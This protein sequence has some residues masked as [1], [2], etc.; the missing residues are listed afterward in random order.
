MASIRA[1]LM[2]KIKSRGSRETRAQERDA[3][4]GQGE[5]EPEPLNLSAN[6]PDERMYSW[7]SQ[8]AQYPPS[9][10]PGISY[11]SRGSE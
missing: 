8:A 3:V 5:I 11:F 6:V 2:T 4:P 10:P 9:G 1:F 7:E